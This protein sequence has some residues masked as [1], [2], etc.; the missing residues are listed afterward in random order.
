MID[1]H[2]LYT[3]ENQNR[4]CVVSVSEEDNYMF[5]KYSK[6]LLLEKTIYLKYL[7]NKKGKYIVNGELHKSNVYS[8]IH[9]WYLVTDFSIK[10]IF[11]IYI[12]SINRYYCAYFLDVGFLTHKMYCTVLIIYILQQSFFCNNNFTCF[13]CIVSL[14]AKLVS[15]L[16]EL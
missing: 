5:L 14:E 12:K 16:I 13:F 7:K 6:V 8:Y 11:N 2:H 1:G 9:L 3:Q 15:K 10:Y 4:L